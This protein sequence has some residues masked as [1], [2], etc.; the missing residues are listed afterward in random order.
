M[1]SLDTIGRKTG[2]DK[3]S[4]HH[5]Y[6]HVYE[7]YLKQY[8]ND[9]ISLIELGVGGYQ[10]ADR[11]GESARMWYEYLT[12]AKIITVDIYPKDNIINDRVEFWQ[13]SQTDVHLLN[14]I[15]DRESN[16][17]QRVVID[18]ASHNNQL[19]IASFHLIFPKLQS[20][21]LYFIEDV[22]T[23]YWENEEYEGKRW[24]G[25][26]VTTMWFFTTLCHQLNAHAFDS[27]HHNEFTGQIEF[28][29]FYKELIVIKKL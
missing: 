2:T 14:T 5:D 16:A 21:D 15:L 1:N 20:G 28:I 25:E 11:G 6:L 12:A 26:P 9:P 10:F 3:S 18:D 22:H 29:H 13:G 4:V 17:M 23:S 24:P 27:K 7:S 8:R 19:T